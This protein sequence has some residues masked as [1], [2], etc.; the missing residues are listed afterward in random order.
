MQLLTAQCPYCSHSVETPISHA[1]RSVRCP[2]CHQPFQVEIPIAKAISVRD[3]ESVD[4]AKNLGSL[5]KEITLHRAHPAI[6]RGRPLATLG[7]F[8]I[9]CV[10][11][12]GVAIAIA[13]ETSWM[14]SSFAEMR[15]NVTEINNDA[16]R[17]LLWASF[18]GIVAVLLTIGYWYLLSLATKLIVTDA[19]TLYQR[20]I[21]KR[22]TSEVQHADVRN[23]QLEQSFAERL[24][25]IGDIAIS[26]AGQD[27]LE[28]KARKIP[29]P[30][31]IISTL[32]EYQHQ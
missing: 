30:H 8:L 2:Q 11:A 21:A 6:F 15:V 14:P 17:W 10:S 26:S 1:S 24:L 3:V 25:G 27:G 9:G 29:S 13:G 5:Q 32:R 23:I 22:E 28:I 4:D 7:L 31:S 19:R 16:P 20:G 12:V 18:A